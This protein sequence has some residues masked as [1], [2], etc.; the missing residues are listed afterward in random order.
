MLFIF[1]SWFLCLNIRYS[2]IFLI[3][4]IAFDAAM[5]QFMLNS[6]WSKCNSDSNCTSKK[7]W[8]HNHCWSCNPNSAVYLGSS[9]V[10]EKR[11]AIK[12]LTILNPSSFE[13]R[14]N[15]FETATPYQSQIQRSAA[16]DW[17]ATVDAKS[18]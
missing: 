9:L 1:S 8:R 15:S 13:A 10:D 4:K 14:L 18:L 11:S 7:S 17:R 6:F 5:S 2:W 12:Y 3:S 16:S